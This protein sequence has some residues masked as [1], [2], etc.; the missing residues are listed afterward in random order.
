MTAD[1]PV[2]P[3]E[4]REPKAE[5]LPQEVLSDDRTTRSWKCRA[6]STVLVPSVQTPGAFVVQPDAR[7]LARDYR[8]RPAT[9]Q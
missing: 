8:L 7:H 9:A 3:C 4:F 6:C 2:I 5:H 1:L